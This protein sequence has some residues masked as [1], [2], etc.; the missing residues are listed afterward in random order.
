MRRN[1]DEYL[2][3]KEEEDVDGVCTLL[4]TGGPACM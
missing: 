1:V 4:T 2:M 3:A